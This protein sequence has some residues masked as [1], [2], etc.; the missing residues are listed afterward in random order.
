MAME[1]TRDGRIVDG[2]IE[3]STA[4]W[5][6]QLEIPD[7]QEG[8]CSIPAEERISFPNMPGKGH[9]LL[10]KEKLSLPWAKLA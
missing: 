2:K 7:R 5:E 6:T 4:L 1:E 3:L 10:G 8:K 9:A